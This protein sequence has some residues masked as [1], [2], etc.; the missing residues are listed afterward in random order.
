[1]CTH[2]EC[3]MFI[4]FII[5]IMLTINILGLEKGKYE[6]HLFRWLED[7]VKWQRA[8]QEVSIVTTDSRLSS[9]LQ[10]DLKLESIF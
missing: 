3:N 5:N 2:I 4:T 6:N 1:M 9:Q 10:S 7:E 8:D